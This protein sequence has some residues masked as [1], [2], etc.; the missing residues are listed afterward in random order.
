VR[1]EVFWGIVYANLNQYVR[2]GFHDLSEFNFLPSFCCVI[3]T[4]E[5]H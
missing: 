3:M 1:F 2:L 4:C 5:V